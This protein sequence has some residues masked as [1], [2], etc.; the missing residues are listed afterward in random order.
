M[1]ENI[2]INPYQ[3]VWFNYP[4]RYLDLSKNFELE[5]RV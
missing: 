1:I 4:S 5:Y 3:Y 2:K